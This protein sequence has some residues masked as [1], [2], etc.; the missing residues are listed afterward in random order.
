MKTILS[1]L[2][3]FALI[4]PMAGCGEAD[5]AKETIE[6]TAQELKDVAKEAAK[7][8]ASKLADAAKKKLGVKEPK[9]NGADKENEEEDEKK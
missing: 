9:K 5:K 7:Q 8:E 2:I 3:A 4:L 6:K 1:L